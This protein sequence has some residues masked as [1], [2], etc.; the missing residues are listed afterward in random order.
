MHT[1][2]SF[3]RDSSVSVTVMY[4][5]FDFELSPPQLLRVCDYYFLL[6]TFCLLLSAFCFLA[7]I[8]AYCSSFSHQPALQL[9]FKP[10]LHGPSLMAWQDQALDGLRHM[11]DDT[12]THPSQSQDRQFF[13]NAFLLPGRHSK[14]LLQMCPS[15]HKSKL[16]ANGEM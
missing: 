7:C 2:S 15:G 13:I 14:S 4:T 6:S 12:T 16:A 11:A 3:C 5:P 10:F 9:T 1:S 8:I